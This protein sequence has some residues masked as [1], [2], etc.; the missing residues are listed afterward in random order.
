MSEPS[1]FF[2]PDER[3]WRRRLNLLQRLILMSLA[4][5][6]LLLVVEI[7]FE[8]SAVM[9]EKWQAWI[10]CIYLP[11]ML[12]LMAVGIVFFRKFGKP[13]IVGLF[14]GLLVLGSLGFWFHSKAKPVASVLRVIA[15]DFE[16]PG[17]LKAAEDQ[18][19]TNPPV[20]APLSLIGLGIIGILAS[21]LPV[22]EK[23]N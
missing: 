3:F 1:K 5:G 9:G 12:I 18:E 4:G 2:D 17:H 8:H 20:L 10:P 16:E 21:L 23:N 14:A 11:I 15:T 6:I 7:R 22:Q 13:L 19:E